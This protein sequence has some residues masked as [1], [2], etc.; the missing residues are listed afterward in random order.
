MPPQ[1]KTD[2]ERMRVRSEII[3]FSNA[4]HV[5]QLRCL[6]EGTFSS[7]YA[8]G[9]LYSWDKQTAPYVHEKILNAV[10]YRLDYLQQNEKGSEDCY[11]LLLKLFSTP[12]AS[13]YVF[14]HFV[15]KRVYSTASYEHLLLSIGLVDKDQANFYRE[16]IAVLMGMGKL[17]AEYEYVETGEEE[18][19]DD[20][21][22]PSILDGYW[23]LLPVMSIDG[24]DVL[25][26]QPAEQPAESP[27]IQNRASPPPDDID[28]LDNS[29]PLEHNVP[30]HIGDTLEGWALGPVA[31]IDGLEVLGFHPIEEELDSRNQN[32]ARSPSDHMHSH[33]GS[34]PVPFEHDGP[35]NIGDALK[36]GVLGPV[37]YTGMD[38]MEILGFHPVEEQ[39]D[40]RNQNRA[41]SPL[42]H[43]DSPH[44]SVPFEHNV[45]RHVNAQT[46]WDAHS[47]GP[48]FSEETSRNAP[49]VPPRTS[50]EP[51][52]PHTSGRT[53]NR[54]GVSGQIHSSNRFY[55]PPPG[56]ADRSANWRRGAK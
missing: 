14:R 29:V 42:D 21:K 15:G 5:D 2:Q 33:H 53:P 28:S 52:N 6:Q 56:A 19:P 26:F 24:M 10:K 50:Y 25:G 37:A 7:L 49:A 48:H 9:I 44:G 8:D 40:S 45:P 34:V 17:P 16:A 11:A 41:H 1:S 35:Q 3:D 18:E 23:E 54:G 13:H 36:G 20:G 43:M 27:N 39:L 46:S 22:K 51:R 31:Y 55:D 4:F 47:S 12:K 38:G 32:R 30:Q